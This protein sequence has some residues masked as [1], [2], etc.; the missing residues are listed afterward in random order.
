MRSAVY[1]NGF[2]DECL[3]GSLSADDVGDDNQNVNIFSKSFKQE[4]DTNTSS[5]QSSISNKSDLLSALPDYQPRWHQQLTSA[6]SSLR[7]LPHP[8]VIKAHLDSVN[9]E[10]SLLDSRIE[11]VL[12]KQHNAA[13]AIA[14]IERNA[15]IYRAPIDATAADD[16]KQGDA[17]APAVIDAIAVSAAEEKLKRLSV[18]ESERAPPPSDSEVE[19]IYETIP[20]DSESE[21]IYCSPYKSDNEADRH[22]AEEWASRTAKNN[23]SAEEHENSSSAYNTGGSCNSYHQLTL[24]L[25]GSPKAKDGS[26]TLVFCPTRHLKPQFPPQDE[27]RPSKK[28]KAA[29]PTHQKH[30]HNEH[31]SRE[32]RSSLQG[33]EASISRADKFTSRLFPLA[34]SNSVRNS[35]SAAASL[36]PGETMYT[37]MANLQQTMLLQ[38]Q[39]FLHALS[40]NNTLCQSAIQTADQAE[41]DATRRHF[42]AP[43]LSQYRFVSGQQVAKTRLPF[44][45]PDFLA[46]LPQTYKATV[47]PQPSEE[48]MEWKVKKRPD[49][50]RYIVRRPVRSKTLRAARAMKIDEERNEH[51]TEDDTISEVKLGR[52]WNKEERKKHMEKARERRQRQE[53]IIATKKQ[54]SADTP[55]V[56][57]YQQK[58]PIDRKTL[59]KKRDAADP[60]ANDN[61]R[62]P[63][64]PAVD[65]K[66]VGMLSVTTV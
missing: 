63:S 57:L 35:P 17:S 48:Q 6:A 51:T 3:N 1:Q 54:S 43:S 64:A 31:Q 41:A 58:Q 4:K 14:D 8:A 66:V 30:H 2:L 24:D 47:Q 23:L 37:N 39:L 38:Q 33:T 21:H 15:A 60:P 44:L 49:G 16:A 7:N 26:K 25:N 56:A 53:S 11:S 34:E 52:Y 55:A 29:S 9:K 12:L 40:Q 46:S 50:S 20:E 22:G 27:Q 13:Q 19:H 28:E 18:S 61:A 32:K 62:Q 42:N 65:P 36:P 59:K 45:E 10:I 5:S